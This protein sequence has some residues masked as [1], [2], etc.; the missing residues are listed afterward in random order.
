[1]SNKCPRYLSLLAFAALLNLSDATALGLLPHQN[2][3]TSSAADDSLAPIEAAQQPGDDVSLELK[4]PIKPTEAQKTESLAAYMDGVAHQKNGNLS[5]ALKAYQKAADSDPTASEPVKAHAMLLMRLGR[6]QQAEEMARK[7]AELN[8][9]D[10]DIRLQ[11]SVLLR[12]RGNIPEAIVLIEEALASRQLKKESSDFIRV[13]SI[14]GTLYREANDPAKAAESYEVLLDSLEKP[15]NYGLDFREHQ[16]LMKDRAT[17][18]EGIGKVMLQIGKYDRAI[19]AFS[20]LTRINQNQPGDHYY[21]LALAQHRKDDLEAA[22]K[23][24]ELYFQANQRNRGALQLLTDIY[25][26]T[27]RSGAIKERLKALE[28]NTTDTSTVQLFLGEFLIDQG[29]GEEAEA[30][31]QKVISDSG[32]ASGYLGLIR[33]D[34]LNHDEK[35]LL[36]RVRKALLA[37][38]TVEELIPLKTHIMNDVDFAKKVVA[39]SI[40]SIDAGVATSPAEAYL[41]SQIAE[42]LEL[43]VEEERLLQATLDSNPD[44][45]MGVDVL[46]RLGLNRLLQDKYAD[47]AK[48]FR[49]LLSVPG[50]P[51]QQQVITLYR[52]SQAE[53]FNENFKDAVIA[54]ETALKLRPEN[55]ELTYQLGWVQ[56]QAK[57]YDSAERNL[58]AAVKLADVDPSLEGRAGILLGAL[59]TQLRRWDDSIAAYE[60]VL[61]IDEVGDDIARRSRTALSNAFVQKGDLA[62]GERIL[63][64]VYAQSPDDP[65][66]NNDL[67]YLYAEQ[68][69]NLDK[70]EKMI[71]IA[72]EAEPDNPAYLDS[73]GWILFRQ[74]KNE[75]ALTVLKKANSDPDYKDATIIE[76]LGDV[77]NALGQKED[78]AKTWQEALDVE[79]KSA[80]PDEEI[81]KRLSNKLAPSTEETLKSPNE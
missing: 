1:M 28:S 14:R 24:L 16:A 45:R 9:D 21:L 77:Q 11:L 19:D 37:R 59:F 62:N 60:A 69:K 29:D 46:G 36:E 26:A 5:D 56:L 33:V 22:E 18:Y 38:I 57:Q 15:E 63:E 55:P 4:N 20:A 3:E 39:A 54:I 81:V 72:V 41:F 64:E 47:S 79:Q 74:N 73:L 49:Q 17:G 58:K 48:T 12:A 52:L 75:E 7:A 66:V 53:V 78:A 32:D 68:N 23:S 67:G 31:F 44:A 13:H 10:F 65:G 34:I 30:V 27:N 35:S 40:A 50:L 42:D 70:A 6:V 80:S 43:P 51:A 61:R 76:H 71:R 25:R 2:D 8:P